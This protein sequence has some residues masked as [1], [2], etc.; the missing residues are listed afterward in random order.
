[1]KNIKGIYNSWM[2]VVAIALLIILIIYALFS[3]TKTNRK[4]AEMAEDNA[5]KRMDLQE[6]QK[7]GQVQGKRNVI[8][9]KG[10][11]TVIF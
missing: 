11:K 8:I 5:E 7:E 4:I 3:A 6:Q 9:K 2:G 10:Q 1:M